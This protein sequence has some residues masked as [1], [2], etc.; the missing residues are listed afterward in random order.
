[1]DELGGGAHCSDPTHDILAYSISAIISPSFQYCLYYNPD[2]NNRDYNRR[3]A[4]TAL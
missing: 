3:S 1:L 2:Y 4:R